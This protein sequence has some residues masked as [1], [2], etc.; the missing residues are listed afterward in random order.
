MSRSKN[1]RPSCTCVATRETELLAHYPAKD[2]S[3]WLGNSPD[4][5]NKHY[6]MTMQ[7][8]FDRAIIEG[9]KIVGVTTEVASKKT[10][11]NP[12]QTLQDN[13]VAIEDKKIAITKNPANNW[14][15]LVMAQ[16]AELLATR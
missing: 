14:K 8:S 10:P 11:P 9:A 4:I 3:S 12:P 5:A 16:N 7:T 1:A 15:C 13:G 2:V 6:A